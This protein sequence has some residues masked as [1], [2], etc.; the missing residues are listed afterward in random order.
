MIVRKAFRFRINTNMELSHQLSEYVGC[1]RFLWNKALALNLSRLE[2]GQKILWYQEL[3]FWTTLWKQSEEYGFLRKAPSQTLQQKLKD[4]DRAFQDAFDKKQ[5]LKRI[6]KFKRKWV[7]D[8]FRFPQGFKILE[9]KNRI[10][11]PKIGWISYRKSRSITGTAKNITIS[12]KGKHWYISIQTEEEKEIKKP[13]TITALGV[14]VGIKR[15]ATLSSGAFFQPLNKFKG[16]KNKLARHQR[17]LAKKVKFSSNWKKQKR[18]VAALHEHIAS[19][20]RDYLHKI[21]TK[22][23]KS[24]AAI[25]VEDLNIKQMTK[26]AKGDA[27]SPGKNV[28][29]K[30]QLNQ[31]ILDQGWRQFVSMLEYKLAWKGGTLIKVPPFHTSQTCPSCKHISQENRKT[32][33]EFECVACGY[34]G[35]SDHV[36]AINILARGLSGLSLWSE[37]IDLTLKQEPAGVSD[38][39]LLL[40]CI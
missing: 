25:I 10:F 36:G 20:R 9:A 16:L 15:L 14:D 18:K 26:S 29:M 11:L 19:A 3:N 28:S 22:I 40:G 34:K 6:P 37:S 13:T 12:R 2:E 32:Q 17:R 1:C 4:L 31:S 23:S 27:S 30:Q 5:P 35:H 39:S 38:K 33:S 21:S 7:S 8:S 24:H